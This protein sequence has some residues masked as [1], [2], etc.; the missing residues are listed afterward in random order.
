LTSIDFIREVEQ[1]YEVASVTANGISVWPFLRQMFF[2]RHVGFTVGADRTSAMSVGAKLRRL[3]NVPHG[4]TRWLRPYKYVSFIGTLDRVL[5]DGLYI[6]KNQEW[7]LQELGK[8]NVLVVE[9]PVAGSH[10]PRGQIGEPNHVS[11][12]LLNCLSLFPS[13]TPEIEGGDI[14]DEIIRRY[15]LRIDYTW[16]IKVFLRQ[17]KCFE[18]LFSRWQP[19]AVFVSCYNGLA[20]Q[21]A[22]RGAR[23]R[24]I[25]TVELQHGLINSKH[26]AYNV[27]CELD[28]SFF[29]DYLLSFGSYVKGVFSPDN[30]FIR[31]DHVFPVGNGY[32]EFIREHYEAHADLTEAISRYDRSVAFTSQVTVEN[33]VIEFVK[34]AANLDEQILHIFIPR[35]WDRDY[36]SVGFPSNVM[37]FRDLDF[38]KIVKFMDF[39]ATVNSTTALEAPALGTPN[40]LVD[41]GGSAKHLYG[42]MLTDPNVTRYVDRPEELVK[43]V[44]NWP[45]RPGPEVAAS[46]S[47]FY[48][49]NHTAAIRHTLNV[50]L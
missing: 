11:L 41:M 35:T 27:F 38:Y 40:I 13:Q 23:A 16:A 14:L 32:L 39:H 24:G 7:L 12:D 49:L 6:S 29:P 20:H 22:I 10:F 17:S 28:P 26:P 1:E 37:T 21:A 36:S 31:D 15:Q 33:E 50:L 44:R 2:A 25:K 46:M 47:H 18:F 42:N 48:E 5:Q 30:H 8:S 45:R 3:K 43:E 9:N 19:D 34:E 4:A